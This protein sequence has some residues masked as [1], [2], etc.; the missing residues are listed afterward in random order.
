MEESESLA[1]C[2]QGAEVFVRSVDSGSSTTDRKV[3]A[4]AKANSHAR[5]PPFQ[6][7]R[8]EESIAR[9]TFYFN[10]TAISRNRAM[11]VT[12]CDNRRSL[13]SSASSSKSGSG[14]EYT[15]VT[16]PPEFKTGLP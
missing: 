16:R 11:G 7:P 12:A 3:S 2:Q 1:E 4:G 9:S 15:P 6:G 14:R 8:F 10:S 13:T 5:N